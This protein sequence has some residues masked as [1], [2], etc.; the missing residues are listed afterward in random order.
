MKRMI[1]LLGF[2]LIFSFCKNKKESSKTPSVETPTPV[3]ITPLNF[4]FDT[5]ELQSPSCENEDEMQCAEVKMKFYMARNGE[6]QARQKINDKIEAVLAEM[7]FLLDD[8]VEKRKDFKLAAKSFIDDYE[9]FI[10]DEKES[11]FITP[12][13]NE[14]EGEILYES[15]ELVCFSFFN[16]N[17]T[18]G[19]HPNSFLR[20]IN[21]DKQ[22]GELISVNQI[23]KNKA[24]L[25]PL[26]EKAVK[27]QFEV[28]NDQTLKDFGFYYEGDT[29]PMNDNI[30]ILEDSLI[31]QYDPYE[32][33]PYALGH[34]SFKIAK[35]EI[36]D[37]L[38]Q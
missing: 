28:S 2:S 15:P 38:L 14:T 21:F 29:F 31:F 4:A 34:V 37:L 9:N 5:Y 27:D 17:Y 23:I 8:E 7:F 10:K 35:S 12:Y 18:G 24:A 11:G 32:I 13:Q 26:A 30:G 36:K 6:E 20:L 22:T 1:M 3:K 16:Y 19:A 33:G 25:A